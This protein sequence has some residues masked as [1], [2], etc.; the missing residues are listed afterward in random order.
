MALAAYCKGKTSIK[1]VSRLKHKE[2]DRALT[3]QQEFFKMGIEIEINGDIMYVFGNGKLT[4]ATVHSHH[5]HR[6]A[7]ACAVAAL[8]AEGET[9]INDADAI[10][11]SYPDFFEFIGK[12]NVN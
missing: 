8:S 6:I 3:L 7:M 9:I 4:G 12:K 5:D 11:K 2:S 1:G 10:N